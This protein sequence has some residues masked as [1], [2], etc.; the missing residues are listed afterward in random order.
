MSAAVVGLAK[1]FSEDGST[2]IEPPAKARLMKQPLHAAV[3]IGGPPAL[4]LAAASKV[5]YGV[6]EYG[7]AGALNGAAIDVVQAET[8]DAL[9]PAHAE[10]VLEGIIRTDVREPEAPFGEASGY[11]GPRKLEKIFEVRAVTQRARP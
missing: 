1:S 5:P 7:L 3:F 9:V 8:F 4:L 6:D 10:I 11:L 2:M